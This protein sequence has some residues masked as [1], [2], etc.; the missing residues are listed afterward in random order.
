MPNRKETIT[1]LR[2]T[3]E[4][5]ILIASAVRELFLVGKNLKQCVD[6]LRRGGG[7][8]EIADG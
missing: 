1:E 6:P 8:Q 3:G 7:L 2:R 5:R 4:I